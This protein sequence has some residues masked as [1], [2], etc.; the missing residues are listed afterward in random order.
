LGGQGVH[1]RATDPVPTGVSVIGRSCHG[2][3][4]LGKLSIEDYITMS[5]VFATA[6]KP[7]YGPPMHTQKLGELVAI[8]PVPVLALGG[9]NTAHQAASARAAGAWGVAV[10][11]AVMRCRDPAALVADLLAAV[12]P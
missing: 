9:I 3:A 12:Q 5:P 8:C 6:S 7:G 11:G 2:R 10:M 1:L 4:D